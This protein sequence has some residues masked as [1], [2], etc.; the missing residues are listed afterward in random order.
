MD[1]DKHSTGKLALKGET[2]LSVVLAGIAAA[3]ACS[4][5]YDEQCR[6][7]KEVGAHFP[8]NYY[9][10][11][12]SEQTDLYFGLL[13][14]MPYLPATSGLE[15]A[16]QAAQAINVI[17]MAY[18]GLPDTDEVNGPFK[19]M[20]KKVERLL[21]SVVRYLEAEGKFS[22]DAAGLG[23]IRNSNGDPW[24]DVDVVVADLVKAGIK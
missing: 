6:Q 9:E 2:A 21:H 13:D 1:T 22:L 5:T 8:A 19:A 16:A 4:E 11:A 10:R 17:S 14:A 24:A 23:S 15:A 3:N 12:S 7:H 20:Q 18:D